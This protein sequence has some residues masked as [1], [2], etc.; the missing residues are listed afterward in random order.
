[1][2]KVK[3]AFGSLAVWKPVTDIILTQPL[4]LVPFAVLAA[5]DILVLLFLASSP[6]TPINF[7]MAPP[8]RR[9]WGEVYLHYPFIY[10]LLPRLVYFTKI[11][12]GIFFGSITTAVAVVAVARMR[13]RE[14][15]DFKEILSQVLKNYISL[16]LLAALLYV[17]VHVS[18]KQPQALLA[19]YFHGH[20]KLLFVGPRL[21]FTLALPVIQF[22]LAVIF[23]ALF[24]YAI[25]FIVLGGKKFLSAFVLGVRFFWRNALKTLFAVTVP[26]ILYI[27]VTMVRTNISI[28]ADKFGPEAIVGVLILGTL[29][30][31]IIV[32]CLITIATT[33]IYIEGHDA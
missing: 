25:P 18:M 28:V 21:W 9:I 33:I 26:M 16:I 20:A 8:I 13:K 27:P 30:S 3:K 17:I 5:I 10:E 29:V 32:D 14:V 2:L 1:V 6:H 4:I 23:Q 19:R 11:L 31:A 7:I 12:T 15:V 22:F 24:V